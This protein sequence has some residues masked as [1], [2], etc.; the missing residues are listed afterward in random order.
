MLESGLTRSASAKFHPS[1]VKLNLIRSFSTI[2]FSWG[3]FCFLA[4]SLKILTFLLSICRF[5]TMDDSFLL[6]NR[7][8][9]R[10]MYVIILW[11]TKYNL[12]HSL[13]SED[14]FTIFFRAEFGLILFYFYICDRTNIL[15]D[16]T[17]VLIYH[18]SCL[19]L[20]LFELQLEILFWSELHKGTFFS[21]ASSVFLCFFIIICFFSFHSFYCY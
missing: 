7:A 3:S 8:T 10:A 20:F 19:H 18:L 6:E 17:K 14:V 9:L 13:N 5:L 11:M 4:L 15:G 12:F 1:S 16:S 2:N 21:K